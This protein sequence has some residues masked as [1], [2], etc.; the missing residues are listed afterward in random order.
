[1]LARRWVSICVQESCDVMYLT[2]NHFMHECLY[3]LLQTT[4]L[5]QQQVHSIQCYLN[6]PSVVPISD[7]VLY[8]RLLRAIAGTEDQGLVLGLGTQSSSPFLHPLSCALYIF[9]GSDSC[10]EGV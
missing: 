1:M 4:S 2:H 3:N 7:V 8:I 10:S 5:V 9:V 6:A